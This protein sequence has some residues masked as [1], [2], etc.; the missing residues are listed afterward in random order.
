MDYLDKR[1]ATYPLDDAHLILIGGTTA[2][3]LGA[4][5]V[6]ELG[7][8][9]LCTWH[10]GIDVGVGILVKLLADRGVETRY[11]FLEERA[12]RLA[13]QVGWHLGTP[14]LVLD[15]PPIAVV[16]RRLL[17]LVC[18]ITA[19]EVVVGIFVC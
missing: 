7:V 11:V 15:S 2:L 9:I 12:H 5:S 19:V 10:I 13:D 1:G 3:G 18:I 16:P 17:P 8:W 6:A 4:M 14:R